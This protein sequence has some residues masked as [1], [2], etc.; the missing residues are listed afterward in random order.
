MKDSYK[1]IID[2]NEVELEV[3][4]KLYTI[5]IAKI[6]TSELSLEEIEKIIDK[7]TTN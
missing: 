7:I 6:V 1:I 5:N 2:L 4:K 3:L